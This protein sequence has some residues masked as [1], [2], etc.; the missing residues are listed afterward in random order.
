MELHHLLV[1]AAALAAMFTTTLLRSFQ[2]KSVAGG[3]KKLVFFVGGLMTAFEGL[4]F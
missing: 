4:V 3:H 1:Y 2:N